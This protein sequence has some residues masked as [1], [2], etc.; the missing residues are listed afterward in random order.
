[1]ITVYIT[2]VI[3]LHKDIIQYCLDIDGFPLNKIRSLW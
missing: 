1:V 3:Q 2:K